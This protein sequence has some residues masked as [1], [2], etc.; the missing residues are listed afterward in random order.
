[1]KKRRRLRKKVACTDGEVWEAVRKDAWFRG[2]LSSSSEDEEETEGKKAKTEDKCARFEE[3][4]RWVRE[5]SGHG[6]GSRAQTV[7]EAVSTG[8]QERDHQ[9]QLPMDE[10]LNAL[11]SLDE[12]AGKIGMRLEQIEARMKELRKE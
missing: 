3:S 9:Q 8:E 6:Q 7:T 5:I 1:M 12:R 4:S 2:L 10:M 11:N